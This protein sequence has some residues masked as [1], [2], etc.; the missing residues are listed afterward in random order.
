MVEKEEDEETP[1]KRVKHIFE[2]MDT[3]SVCS[4]EYMSMCACILFV[5]ECI[6]VMVNLNY[7]LDVCMCT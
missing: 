1:Q 4:C 6:L 2:S 5:H 7:V 3:V